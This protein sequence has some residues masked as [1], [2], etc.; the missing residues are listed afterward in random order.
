MRRPA[1][2]TLVAAGIVA[3]VA[4]TLGVVAFRG[5]WFH[6][7]PAV[8]RSQRV[9]VT[10]A[11]T[12]QSHLFADSVTARLELVF[13]RLYVPADSVRVDASFAP[14]SLQS[15]SRERTDHGGTTRLTYRFRIAC[16]T[17]ACLPPAT[18]TTIELPDAVVGYGLTRSDVASTTIVTWPTLSVA[19]RIGLDDSERNLLRVSAQPVS[20]P[21]FRISPALLTGLALAGAVALLLVAA[22][23]LVPTLPHT[24]GLRVPAWARRRTRPLTPLE[25]ALARASTA[26]TNGGGDERRALEHLALELAGSGETGLAL[27]ARRMAWSPGRPPPQRFD[28]LFKEVERVIETAR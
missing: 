14:F 16:L 9:F 1:E 19:A 4:A 15:S 2:R 26:G 8:A 20:A 28:E 17:Q 18:G 21:T 7:E 5:G 6:D 24:L 12:P 22:V 25:Q 3:V 23:L 27:D 10:T 11:L 13:G